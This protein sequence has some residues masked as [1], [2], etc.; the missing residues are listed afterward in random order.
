MP[1]CP[2]HGAGPDEVYAGA[3]ALMHKWQREGVLV[4]DAQ[5]CVY[6]YEQE[7]SWAGRS[8]TRRALLTGVRA[9]SLGQDVIPHE[10]T[11]AGPKQ[12][13]LKLTRATQMQ[14]SPI[15]GF[16]QDKEGRAGSV[17]K[18]AA[19]GTPTAQGELRGTKERLWAI[20]DAKR[21]AALGQALSDVPVF[22]ADG[23]HRYTTGLNYRN[24]LAAADPISPGH[25]AN[26]T[27]F[28]LVASDDP[29]LIILPTHRLIRGLSKD[30]SVAKLAAAAKE[31]HWQDFDRRELVVERGQD[32][33]P[34]FGG[35]AIA[36]TGQDQRIWIGRLTD[37]AAMAEAVP[38]HSDAWRSLS[39]AILHKLI[40]DRAIEAFKTDHYAI[41][42]TAFAS[43]VLDATANGVAQLGAFV[44]HST[45]EQIQAIASHG[46]SMPQKS[47]FFYPKLAT[48]MVLKPLYGDLYGEKQ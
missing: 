1:H 23:H 34:G 45:I 33:L 8:Y 21:I 22:I 37:K 12:D 32:F 31:F 3:A 10:H 44:Q 14:L 17:L 43:D 41:D 13:R 38:D 26:F 36:L 15:F 40:L 46:E 20:S 29:G 25:E 5:P 47:T 39:T 42:Y 11:H 19:A 27:M 7:Y 9:T 16:Y 2:P 4:Q 35:E 30:F 48:G 28:A 6:V 24:E 18:Q